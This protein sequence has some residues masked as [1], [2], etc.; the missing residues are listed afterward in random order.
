M[1]TLKKQFLSIIA[2]CS[3]IFLNAQIPTMQWAN[4]MGSSGIDVGKSIAVNA[5]GE[6]YTCGHFN[7]TVDFDPGTTSFTL[8]SSGL[9]D[10]FV[11]K[12]DIGGYFVWAKKIGGTMDDFATGIAIDGAGN[13]LLTGYFNGTADFDPNA[14]TYSLTAAGTNPDIFVAKLTSVGNFSWATKFGIVGQDHGY[15]ITVDAANNVYTTGDFQ[16][17]VD[18]DPGVGTFTLNSF[19]GNPD[20]FISKLDASGNFL[21]ALRMGGSGND[22]GR[23]IAVDGTGNIYTTGYFFGTADYD[24]GA[25]TISLTAATGGGSDIFVSK[26]NNLGNAVFAKN[27]GGNGSDYGLSIKLDG[28]GNVLT[29]GYF[30]GSGDFDPNAGTFSLSV[31]GNDDIFI[32]K[33]DATGNFVWAKGMGGSGTDLGNG[34]AVDGSGN[35]YTSGSFNAT[36]DFDPNATT[37]TLTSSGLGDIFINKLNSAGNFMWAAKMGGTQDD[38]GNAITIDASGYLYTTGGFKGTVDFDPNTGTY[39]LTSSGS[40][41]DIFVHK[42]YQCTPPTTPTNVTLVSN[43]SICANKNTTLTASGTGTV[44][45][46]ANPTGGVSLATG[47]SYITPTLSVGSY[48]YYAEATTCTVSPSRATVTVIVN[49]NPTVTATSSSSLI[50]S[51]VTATLSASGATTFTWNPGALTGSAVP[52]TPTSSTIYSLTAANSFGCTDAKTVS[53]TVSPCTNISELS[54]PNSEFLIYPNPNNGKFTVSVSERGVY[55][56]VNSIGQTVKMI[57]INETTQKIDLVDLAE[58]MYYI[59]G[60]KANSKIM[61]TQ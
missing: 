41:D 32:S 47:A 55:R 43:Q 48:T 23:S 9:T 51:G 53:I 58:G 19:A 44:S 33:L 1:K 16:G 56:I 45:W 30:Q 42:M 49:P 5:S 21:S 39:S 11:T 25:G 36:T 40:S 27:M 7:G 52:V 13:V 20:V 8:A 6:V 35:V 37:Y 17:T 28:T 22:H 57:T 31:V 18:F 10:I 4:K 61:I 2:L 29:T 3:A 12:F 15:G 26:V 38:Y 50:C 54:T 24:P 59:I 34:I 60:K 46:F 14:G